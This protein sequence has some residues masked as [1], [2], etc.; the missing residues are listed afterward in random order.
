MSWSRSPPRLDLAEECPR[1]Q[2]CLRKLENR[3]SAIAFVDEVGIL[4]G[5]RILK[6]ARDNPNES[7]TDSGVIDPQMP[8]VSFRR[9]K[10]PL[11]SF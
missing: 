11:E 1:C 3:R 5:E 6:P 10:N 9:V 4:K 7:L 2:P 8:I